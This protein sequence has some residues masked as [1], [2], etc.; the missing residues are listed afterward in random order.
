MT[1]TSKKLKIN[2]FITLLSAAISLTSFLYLTYAWFTFKREDAV[3]VMSVQ[4]S[5]DISY[6][7]KYFTKN[8]SSFGTPSGYQSP[9]VAL[10]PGDIVTVDDYETQ[11]LPLSEDPNLNG[12]QT[13]IINAQYPSLRFTY[14]VE[15]MG[16]FSV[17][18]LVSL[19][20]TDYVAIPSTVFYNATTHAPINLAQAINIYGTSVDGTGDVT[21]GANSFVTALNQPDLF[22][23]N[24]P[25]GPT[26]IVLAQDVLEYN[27]LTPNKLIFF[28]TIEYSNAPGT[29]YSYSTTSSGIE[30]Y[31]ADTEGNSNVYKN[32][33]FSITELSISIS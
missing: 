11:F 21:L 5:G 23:T 19:N 4:A 29:Y 30:Y 32:L 26:N 9:D 22:A 7:L 28:F 1:P 24:S 27:E 20:L 10:S 2:L 17:D 8:Y 6:E 3:T 33:S 15:I 14:A 16:E 13:V 25:S 18:T 31:L 12:V